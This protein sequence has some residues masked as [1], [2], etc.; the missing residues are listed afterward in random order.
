[1]LLVSPGPIA[2]A[3]DDPAADRGTDRYAADVARAG[4]P[5]EAAAPGGTARLR[6]LDPDWLA[7]RVLAA[8]RQRHSELVVPRSA[9]FVAGLIDLFPDLGRQLLA[10]FTG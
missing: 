2:G 10:R 5:A 7:R 1:V 3:A 4:L 9:G 8:C 6:R